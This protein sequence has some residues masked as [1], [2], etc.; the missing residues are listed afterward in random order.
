M[1]TCQYVDMSVCQYVRMSICQKATFQLR[2]ENGSCS[3]CQQDVRKT[4]TQADR[5][6]DRLTD[7]QKDR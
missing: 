3:K 5:H 7:R 6:T 2:Y 4:E 1:S